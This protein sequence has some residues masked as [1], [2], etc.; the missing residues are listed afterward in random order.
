MG[1]FVTVITLDAAGDGEE[2]GVVDEAH[3]GVP[4]DQVQLTAQGLL[5]CTNQILQALAFAHSQGV[6]HGDVTAENI[7]C[8]NH[9]KFK[10]C[11]LGLSLIRRK[12]TGQA[13]ATAREDLE[14]LATLLQDR[15][16]QLPAGC[17]QEYGWL[18]AQLTQL[19]SDPISN[20]PRLVVAM[21]K[22]IKAWGDT[23]PAA[24]LEQASQ[25]PTQTPAAETARP[26]LST[27]PASEPKKAAGTNAPSE[28]PPSAVPTK[29]K[30]QSPIALSAIGVAVI[31]LLL[32]GLFLS[33]VLSTPT[34]P[35]DATTANKTEATL[36]KTE[37]VD[38]VIDKNEI[39]DMPERNRTPAVA[40]NP[41]TETDQNTVEPAESTEKLDDTTT[42]EIVDTS[43]SEDAAP[44]DMET[45]SASAPKTSET[46]ITVP[47]QEQ[48][49]EDISLKHVPDLVDLPTSEFKESFTIGELTEDEKLESL[50]VI[51]A[52]VV[53]S[54]GKGAFGLNRVDEISWEIQLLN[55][56]G[57]S[58][59][60]V[61]AFEVKDNLLTFTWKPE[62]SKKSKANALRNCI[63]KLTT[64]DA[65]KELAL[66]EPIE[67]AVQLNAKKYG[68]KI[69]TEA[70]WLPQASSIR[71]KIDIPLE[72]WP[73]RLYFADGDSFHEAFMFDEE[74]TPLAILF[75]SDE[76]KQNLSI[77]LQPV[78]KK[79]LTFN[80]GVF[81]KGKNT[82]TVQYQ[83]FQT[84]E[85]TIELLQGARDTQSRI[86]QEA[87]QAV[88]HARQ[89]RNGTIGKRETEEKAARKTY[90]EINDNVEIS[91][92]IR[93]QLSE[94]HDAPL[95]VTVYFELEGRQILVGKTNK[96]DESTDE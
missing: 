71:V 18:G 88:Q 33:G 76:K 1:V 2:A 37:K 93:D 84:A 31:V 7:A 29:V 5:L 27:R 52:P 66:R 92:E 70:D 11:G 8:V 86:K 47:V 6:V 77:M 16:S 69:D 14:A 44:T 26:A 83:S 38:D 22:T 30:W 41:T 96:T 17:R 91:T 15:F 73:R 54:N 51:F 65:T 3:G 59:D 46:Q 36:P 74:N 32:G 67:L 13:D 85:Q 68:P 81:A 10:I 90:E 20:Y 49:T 57:G 64:G 23:K 89:I 50:E 40:S 55:K 80:L 82:G 34:S 79:K 87:A 62:V 4:L 39:P 48:E 43:S 25:Q 42:P 24:T 58:G 75:N 19:K 21:E 28:T 78:V 94:L 56:P 95:P 72:P 63:L 45:M 53:F 35:S 12:L 61:A 60:A 9:S